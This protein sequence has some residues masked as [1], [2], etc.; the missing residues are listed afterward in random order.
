MASLTAPVSLYRDP[1]IFERERET[2]FARSWQYMGLEADLH[3]A[4]DFISQTLADYPVFVVR[5][6]GGAL[7]GFHNVCPH[8]AGPLVG[9]ARGR[10]DR[11]IVCRY[12]SWR[13]GFDGRLHAATGFGPASGLNIADYG[14]FP[15][16]VETWCGFVFV[17]LDANA[18]PLSETTRPLDARFGNRSRLSARIEDKHRIACNWKVFTENYLEGYHIGG[19]HQHLDAEV[20]AGAEH[21]VC[22]DGDV[23]YHEIDAAKGDPK[24]LW[25]WVWPNLGLTLNRGV[26]CV[27]QIRPLGPDTTLIEHLYLHEPEEP[28]IDA[29]L[30]ASEKITEEDAW[31]CERVQRNLDAGIYKRG[32]LS[33][34]NESSVAWF[35]ARVQRA[36]GV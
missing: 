11:E 29:A 9:E 14:L 15:V 13:F 33:E 27:A 24:A 6:E 7:R 8:R 1:A 10:C 5:D 16:R 22:I 35:Q 32:P 25:A 20:H 3:R 17:N 34:A 26:L 23:A 28:G 4:G 19:V 21:K 30:Y 12:H 18:A 31:I 2:I 36:L